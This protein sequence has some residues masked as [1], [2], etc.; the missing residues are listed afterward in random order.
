VGCYSETAVTAAPA[1]SEQTE[2][3]V[4]AAQRYS[5]T[6]APAVLAALE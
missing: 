5:A 2:A 1:V 3:T 6:E 4:E